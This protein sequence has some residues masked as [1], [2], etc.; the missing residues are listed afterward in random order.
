MAIEA[1]RV[2]GPSDPIKYTPSGADV[3]AGQVIDMGTW[4]AVAICDITDGVEGSLETEG[5]YD[6]L[7]YS[8][9][10]VTLGATVYWDEGTNTATTTSGYG[11]AVIGKC[12]Y[13]AGAS[14]TRVRVKLMGA[15][16]GA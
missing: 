9:Q 13:A 16:G 1:I 15:L 12:T 14:D 10:A 11:E 4:V 5:Q 6:F 2:G 3:A 7:K 8:A